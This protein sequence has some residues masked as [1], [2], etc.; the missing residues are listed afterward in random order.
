[1]KTK[2]V[3]A[4]LE[5]PFTQLVH[6]PQVVHRGHLEPDRVQ[7][8]SLLSVKTGACPAIRRPPGI[9]RCSPASA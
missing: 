5:L 6:R 1:M 4:L 3:L 2:N 7:L 8:S 9:A